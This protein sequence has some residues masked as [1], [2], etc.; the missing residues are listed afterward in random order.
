MKK[1]FKYLWLLLLLLLPTQAFALDPTLSLPL[2]YFLNGTETIHVYNAPSSYKLYYQVQILDDSYT[3]EIKELESESK[4]L[5][6]EYNT[7]SE[8]KKTCSAITDTSS[9]EYT[10]CMSDYNTLVESYNTKATTYS[11]K[12]DSFNP[13]RSDNSWIELATT[14][15][16]G[17]ASGEFSDPVKSLSEDKY[18]ALYAKLEG[19]D[20]IYEKKI[21]SLKASSTSSSSTT[22]KDTSTSSDKAKVTQLSSNEENPNTMDKNII[23]LV[24]SA[25]ACV[26]VFVITYKKYKNAK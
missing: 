22:T 2:T 18:I 14:L 13:Q 5:K 8:K 7:L 25:L 26:V 21:Y 16:D 3:T 1:S 12:Y 24:S 10:T 4:A 17:D 23:Y 9:T 20:V 19:S 6:E 15:S 11:E